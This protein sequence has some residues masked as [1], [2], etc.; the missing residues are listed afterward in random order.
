MN[1]V[2]LNRGFNPKNNLEFIG[3]ATMVAPAM[4]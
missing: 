2:A 3:M 1:I 4:M